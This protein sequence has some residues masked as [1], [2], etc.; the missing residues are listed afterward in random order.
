MESSYT[1]GMGSHIVRAL[2]VIA[3]LVTTSAVVQAESSNTSPPTSIK[4]GD[5][6]ALGEVAA[7]LAGALIRELSQRGGEVV[8]DYIE[9]EVWHGPALEPNEYVGEFRLK[10]YPHGKSKSREHLKADT[11]Y[12]FS[13]DGVKEFEITTSK[14]HDSPDP[15]FF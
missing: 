12:R 2:V 14:G 9:A 11:W 8:R 10:L 5:L 15:D 7:N 3:L 6:E 13:K 1:L 4:I